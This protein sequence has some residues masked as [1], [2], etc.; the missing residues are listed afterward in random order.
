MYVGSVAAY[1]TGHHLKK[2]WVTGFTNVQFL[3]G[4]HNVPNISGG[5]SWEDSPNPDNGYTMVRECYII[6]I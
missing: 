6:V 5:S 1:F 4:L 3:M 2:C